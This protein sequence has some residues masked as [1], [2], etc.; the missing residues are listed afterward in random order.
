M[1]INGFREA[2]SPFFFAQPPTT[3]VNVR[4]LAVAKPS[5][6]TLPTRDA[7]YPEFAAPMND[8]RLATDYRAH[9]EVNIPTGMQYASR[10]FMQK[11]AEAIM[12]Q[13]RKRHAAATGAG[14]YYDATT[15][16]PANAYVKCDTEHCVRTETNKY[17]V[18]VERYEPTPP[19]FGTYGESKPSLTKQ[20]KPLVTQVQEGG[21]N[22]VR[23]IDS[24]SV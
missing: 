5:A 24:R 20:F 6:K 19:L 8:G 9:C 1:D 11:N 21:R 15:L 22:S 14:G 7:I 17:G 2:Q 23:G 10:Q 3:L 16:M 12:S 13:A 4:N 18:G